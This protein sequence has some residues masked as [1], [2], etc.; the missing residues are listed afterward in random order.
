[1]SEKDWR[2]WILLSRLRGLG[3]VG[4]RR[5]LEHFGSPEALFN[6]ESREL[7]EVG[8]SAAASAQIQGAPRQDQESV[9]EEVAA[10]R[11]LGARLVT[12]LDLEYP[13]LLKEIHNPPPLL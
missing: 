4:V 13:V 2:Y 10:M 6:A 11:R 12:F 1:M 9:D 5:V 8:F 3:D 7:A